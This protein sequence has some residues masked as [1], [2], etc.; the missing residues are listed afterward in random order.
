MK[1]KEVRKTLGITQKT[2]NSYSKKGIIKYVAINPYHYVYDNE[3][4]YKLIGLSNTKKEKINV[5]YSRVSLSKQK[6]DLI[7]QEK[8]LMDFCVSKGIVIN[9]QY[10]DIKSGMNFS[11]RKFFN[12]LLEEVIKGNI[13]N[14]VVEHKDRLCRFGFDLFETFC[15]FFGTKI[16]VATQTVEKNY[17][18]ELTEDLVSIIH[19]FSM[20]SYS[21]RRKLNQFKKELQEK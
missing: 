18:Q 1:A 14:I 13:D 7:S 2:L 6:N 9:K 12:E 5:T 19:Y 17:E 16:V 20:K 4:V 21:H 10:Q 11:D 3:D 8:R 15:R